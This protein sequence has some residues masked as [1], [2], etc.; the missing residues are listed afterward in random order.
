MGILMEWMPR[1]LHGVA[2]TWL[3]WLLLLAVGCLGQ[4]S[5]ISALR[6]RYEKVAGFVETVWQRPRGE[7]RGIV[8]IAHGC[9]HQ[10]TDIFSDVGHD[11]WR[12][13]ACEGSNFGRQVARARGYLVMAVSGGSGVQ[14]CWNS[15]SDV[16]NVGKA[17]RRVREL[18]H[19]PESLPIFAVGAS[20]G[21]SFVGR[22]AATLDQGGL[23]GL[24]CIVPQ[25]MGIRAAQGGNRRGVPTL[26]VHMPRDARTAAAVEMDIADLQSDGVRTKE[27]RVDPKP[28]TAELLQAC[29][30]PDA[31]SDVAAA[32]KAAG[33]LDVQGLLKKDAR[34]R[35]WVV[36]VRR[37]LAGRSEDSLAPDESCLAEV[38]NVAWA[39]HEFTAEHSEMMLDFCEVAAG[40]AATLA[41]DDA[42]RA[43]TSAAERQQRRAAEF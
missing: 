43:Q 33:L 32:V 1:Q 4:G 26:F 6:P 3:S 25:I 29:L 30:S 11:G 39:M 10:A 14:S 31:A 40:G 18:E 16:S 12:F 21:G 38:F 9:M 8:F 27:I 2:L 35:L 5:D 28:V 36:P 42:G 17:V 19:L 13:E 22:L 7:I 15:R 20:S 34:S 41:G 23:P 37:A 24:Q